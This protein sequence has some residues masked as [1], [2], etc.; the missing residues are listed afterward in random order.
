TALGAGDVH[1]NIEGALV[2]RKL[3]AGARVVVRTAGESWSESLASVLGNFV[4]LEPNKLAAGSLALA[5]IGTEML[6]HF[7]TGDALLRALRHVVRPRASWAGLTIDEPHHRGA[8]LL[9]AFP[10]HPP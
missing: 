6:G 10:A 2:A 9:A 3:N 5:A 4:A 7:R 8:V 1:A